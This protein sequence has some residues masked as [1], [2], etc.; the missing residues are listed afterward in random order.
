MELLKMLAANEVVAQILSFLVLFFILRAFAWKKILALL[1]ERKKKIA[2]QLNR[3]EEDKAS[4]EK[5]KLEYQSRLKEA[6]DASKAKIQEAIFE[7]QKII[8]DCKVQARKEADRI[9][10]EAKAQV[11]YEVAKVKEGLK[12]QT[13]DLVL[14]ATEHLLEEKMND[15]KDRAII[16]DFLDKLGNS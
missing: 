5:I 12:A 2:S 6:E 9:I 1:D 14:D 3:A 13:I 4:I 7:G 11:E 16:R 10:N 8:E 15:Q